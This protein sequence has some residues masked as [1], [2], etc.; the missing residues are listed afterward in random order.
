MQS[1]IKLEIE[2]VVE[3][4][5]GGINGLQW[6]CNV[7]LTLAKEGTLKVV[8]MAFACPGKVQRELPKL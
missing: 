3:F 5:L 6:Y 2:P 7:L 4:G 8:P 1:S